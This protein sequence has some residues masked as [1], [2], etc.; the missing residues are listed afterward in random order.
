MNMYRGVNASVPFGF[1]GEC[2]RGSIAVDNLRGTALGGAEAKLRAL[3]PSGKFIKC[4][5]DHTDAALIL[6]LKGKG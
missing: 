4:I 6:T 1:D 2:N 3:I 5:S